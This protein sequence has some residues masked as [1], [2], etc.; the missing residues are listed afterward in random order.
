MR[1][2]IRNWPSV[3]HDTELRQEGMQADTREDC[4]DQLQHLK[5]EL[6]K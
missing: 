4:F 1:R 6:F 2:M 5:E 3:A